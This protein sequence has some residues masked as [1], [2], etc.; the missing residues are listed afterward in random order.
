MGQKQYR[1]D[2]K[3]GLFFLI[4]IVIASSL[5][6]YRVMTIDKCPQVNVTTSETTI[7]AG[8][9]ITYQIIGDDVN[10]VVWDFGDNTSPAS[11][12]TQIHSY[13]LAGEYMIRLTINGMYSEVKNIIVSQSMSVIN[14][15]LIPRISCSKQGEIGQLMR[16]LC[17]TK[18][19]GTYEW[20]FGESGKVDS[21][22]Q[23]PM[24]KF[25]TS[26]VKTVSLVVNGNYKYLAKVDVF[27]NE[28]AKPSSKEKPIAPRDEVVVEEKIPEKAEDYSTFEEMKVVNKQPETVIFNDAEL[29]ASIM[30][31]I[32]GK[33]TKIHFGDTFCSDLKEIGIVANEKV[34][35]LS[36]FLD[37]MRGQKIEIRRF[38]TKRKGGLETGC[39]EQVIVEYK[40]R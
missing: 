6:V 8:E 13:Q 29:K 10:H 1:I 32:T 24:Y 17:L 20:R 23:N 2:N 27:I 19:A 26:G 28:P 31:Y 9:V 18:K 25:A 35:K 36:S 21:K 14:N 11:G 40:K 4:T 15:D 33:S 5:L 16:F 39:V 38:S 37:Q 22:L 7:R 12:I 3:V 34:I 30:S